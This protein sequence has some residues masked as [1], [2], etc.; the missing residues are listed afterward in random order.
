M[1]YNKKVETIR[2]IEYEGRVVPQPI[3]FDVSD[4]YA[5]IETTKLVRLESKSAPK[6]YT[7]EIDLA[8]G[9]GPKIFET[10]VERLNRNRKFKQDAPVVITD[11]IG[12]SKDKD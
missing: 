7:F 12:G 4:S 6:A 8:K 10:Q 2:L 3:H 11:F 5:G 9:C 1:L